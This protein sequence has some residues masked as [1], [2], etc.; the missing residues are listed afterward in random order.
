MKFSILKKSLLAFTLALALQS[1]NGKGNEGNM[2]SELENTSSAEGAPATSAN[3]LNDTTAK[4]DSLKND[5]TKMSNGKDSVQGEV[6][7][8][9]ANK[10]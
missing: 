2:E 3:T 10:Q 4:Q 8:P 9:N 6:T 5:A 1:C 7:P